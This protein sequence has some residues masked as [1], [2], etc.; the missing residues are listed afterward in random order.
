MLWGTF[1]DYASY[2][3]AIVWMA[4]FGYPLIKA[5]F[6]RWVERCRGA[7]APSVNHQYNDQLNI[8]MR[9]YPE[10]PVTWFIALFLVSFTIIIALLANGYMFI[11]IWTYFIAM[12]TGAIVVVV[13]PASP[14][15]FRAM[16][17]YFDSLWDGFTRYLIFNW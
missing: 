12:A 3:S 14:S 7:K 8:L 6:K 11:P 9:E 1:F 17:T 4:L 15:K 16:L 13:S 5:S 10:V 2:T